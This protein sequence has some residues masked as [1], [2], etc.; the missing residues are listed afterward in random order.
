M[1]HLLR[2]VSGVMGRTPIIGL[3]AIYG[4]FGRAG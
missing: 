4:L 2:F 1:Q 3:L